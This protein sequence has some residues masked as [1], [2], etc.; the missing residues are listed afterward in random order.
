MEVAGSGGLLREKIRSASVM[1]GV[2]DLIVAGLILTRS[3]GKLN[4][5]GN[6]CSFCASEC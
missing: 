2:E 4:C 5:G 1:E 3:R 6:E